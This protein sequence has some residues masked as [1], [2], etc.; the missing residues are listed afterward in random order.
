MTPTVALWAPVTTPAG[1][2]STRRFIRLRPP[3]WAVLAIAA[4]GAVLSWVTDS[5]WQLA[6]A[7]ALLVTVAVDAAT[8]F[9]S[10]RRISITLDSDRLLTTG[11][12]MTCTLRVVGCR[13]PVVLAPAV[14]P[15]V[16]RFLID[17]ERPGRIVLAPRRRGVVHGVLVD[18][19]AT[20]P[21]GLVQCAR[22][23]RVPL[24]TTLTVG[25]AP[26]P[27]VIEWPRPRAVHFGL[28]DSTPIGDELYRSVRPYLRGDSRRRVH[29]KASAH[30]G[31]LMVKE[32]EG[33]GV[34]VLRIVV[35]LDGPSAAA[36]AALGRASFLATSALERGWRTELVTMQPV[37]APAAPSLA[38]GS[39]FGPP[40]LDV[41]AIVAP[42]RVVARTVHGEPAVRATLATASYGPVPLPRT[43]GL[44][45]LVTTGGDRWV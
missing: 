7:V 24:T 4:V 43:G 1:A 33:T 6:I 12:P 9:R 21:V 41:Q 15:S 36:E 14:R 35:S 25:P 22:R 44:T 29:W 18:A 28:S 11:D 34:V 5:R 27:H 32:L 23:Q 10:M 42:T 19:V 16:Q 45:L 30:R 3:A 13:R 17:D 20:G 37:T 39:P 26:L 31:D 2:A 40:P 38:L 8:A